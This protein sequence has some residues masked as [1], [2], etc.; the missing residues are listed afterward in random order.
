MS[1]PHPRRCAIYTRKSS[2][3]GLDQAFNSLHAQRE[4]CES[5]VRSQSG[6]GWRVIPRLY[7]DGGFSG[8][9]MD[10]PA[11]RE[12]L[13][14]IDRGLVDVVVVY[15][16]DRLTRS[17][18][19]FA[20]IVEA[21]DRK[22]VSF[23]SITQQFNT[24][25]SMG[26]LT[27]NVLLS[28]AQ[29]E[30]EVTG[31]RIR[32]KIAA[33]KA[34]GMWMG[35]RPPFGYDLP[36]D[37]Q[38]RALVVNTAEAETVRRIFSRY[39]ELKSVHRLKDELEAEGVRSRVWTDRSGRIRGGIPL[40]RGPLFHLLRNRAYLGEV[41]HRGT[42]YP[43]GHPPIVKLELFNQVQGLL[44][45]SPR[46]YVY[47]APDA[48]RETGLVLTGLL[49]DAAGVRMTPSVTRKSGK[50]SYRYY[51]STNLMRGARARPCSYPRRAPAA[52]IESIVVDAVTSLVAPGADVRAPI[53]R[54]QLEP[55]QLLIELKR[56]ALAPG[57]RNAAHLRS[58]VPDGAH[59]IIDEGSTDHVLVV[60]APCRLHRSAGVTSLVDAEGIPIRTTAVPDP[61][62]IKSLRT[63]HR[64]VADACSDPAAVFGRPERARMSYSFPT[65]YERSLARLAFLAPD[66][67]LAILEGRQTPQ[68]SLRKLIL[69]EVPISWAKQRALFGMPPRS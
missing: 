3:E 37:P 12:L 19:D 52:L 59:I 2:E 61:L 49:Y 16:V 27:L 20:R 69:G 4:A 66:I 26:R 55:D 6:E 43:G 67:Q 1:Q 30:R 24:T 5:Y 23:V 39:L 21:F 57:L 33:S 22:G 62:L 50:R 35:G 18:G 41:P 11:L 34:K 15:K 64:M 46:R 60:R 17:L 45:E 40:T 31:E 29:F 44:D 8:G 32:D 13:A 51:V 47:K 25:S 56:S 7:D 68:L 54:V 48:D 10:R 14:D 63:G 28:F 9:S 36:T 42:F 65:A 53:S 38:T 58:A